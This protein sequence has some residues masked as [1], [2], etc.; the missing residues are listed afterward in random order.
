MRSMLMVS[1]LDPI[2]PRGSDLYTFVHSTLFDTWICDSLVKT[3]FRLDAIVRYFVTAFSEFSP[4]I[5]D[6]EQAALQWRFFIW[7]SSLLG[8]QDI[9]RQTQTRK[10]TATDDWMGKS[11]GNSTAAD[12]KD[13][14]SIR[15][16]DA[17]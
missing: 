15:Q 16:I 10:S 4:S 5:F 13:R 7:N 2:L 12:R 8:I 9:D 14:L 11:P 6:S 1:T 17:R 3:F